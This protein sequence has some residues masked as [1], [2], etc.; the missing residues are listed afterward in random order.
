M[1]LILDMLT[2]GPHKAEWPARCANTAR[3]YRQCD[4][5]QQ[6][7]TVRS[8]MTVEYTAATAVAGTSPGLK[9]LD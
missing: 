9:A 3:H 2:T 7:R 4:Q 6:L 1:D 8:A 5:R